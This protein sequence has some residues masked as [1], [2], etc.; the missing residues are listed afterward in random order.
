MSSRNALAAPVLKDRLTSDAV[1]LGELLHLDPRQVVR[2]QVIQ[3]V[4]TK[5]TLM[6]PLLAILDHRLSPS[7]VHIRECPQVSGLK[8]EGWNRPVKGVGIT[9]QQVHSLSNSQ[10]CRCLAP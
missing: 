5:P 2:H 10:R 6:L 1:A 7:R 3:L 9:S 4:L 8:E